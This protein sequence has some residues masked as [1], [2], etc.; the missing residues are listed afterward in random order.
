MRSAT[1]CVTIWNCFV[2]VLM[3]LTIAF[4][5]FN[6]GASYLF[7]L[8]LLCICSIPWAAIFEIAGVVFSCILLK[9]EKE[10]KYL[11]I[12]LI[13]SIIVGAI[14]AFIINSISFGGDGI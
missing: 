7:P 9:R 3:L 12:N 10:Y 6:I 1:R 2:S 5:A 11:I 14:S 4:R 13:T 8:A